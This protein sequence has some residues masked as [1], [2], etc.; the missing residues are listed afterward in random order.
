MAVLRRYAAE[1]WQGSLPFLHVIII[2]CL[3]YLICLMILAGPG[4][5]MVKIL[6]ANLV[7]GLAAIGVF[8]KIRQLL[9][10]SAGMPAAALLTLGGLALLLS[11]ASATLNAVLPDVPAISPYVAPPAKVRLGQHGFEAVGSI[12]YRMLAE[13]RQLSAARPEIKDILLHSRG[14]Y[15]HAG[16]AMGMFI[17]DAGM[18]TRVE[19]PCFSACTLAFAGGEIRQLGRNGRLGFHGYRSDHRFRLPLG[20]IEQAQRRDQGFLRSRGFSAEFV[21][22]AYATHSGEL[23]VP[24]LGILRR[25]GVLTK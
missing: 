21:A 16:R 10:I 4:V 5:T 19:G 15:V 24:S 18:N 23:W 9:S 8:R 6:L 12:D 1:F 25:A 13:L 22:R 17:A 7:L 11:A 3:S 20:S 14:G 2:S